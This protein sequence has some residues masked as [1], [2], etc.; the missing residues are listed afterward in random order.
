ML[1][2]IPFKKQ[3]NSALTV[4]ITL[5]YNMIKRE[6]K[7]TAKKRMNRGRPVTYCP[8]PFVVA[9]STF[10]LRPN[11]FE[12]LVERVRMTAVLTYPVHYWDIYTRYRE[13]VI[14]AVLY[15]EVVSFHT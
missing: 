6:F 5:K 2:R 13:G 8:S 1:A 9:A 15:R 14:R 7:Q 10:C 12:N 11:I 3:S 4:P